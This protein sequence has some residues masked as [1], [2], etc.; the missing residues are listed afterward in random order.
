MNVCELGVGVEWGEEESSIQLLR[1]CT[2]VTRYTIVSLIEQFVLDLF[3][4]HLSCK[5]ILTLQCP[6]TVRTWKVN[7][8]L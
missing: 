2:L 6:S 1:D 5:K 3:S 8:S 7:R 4:M